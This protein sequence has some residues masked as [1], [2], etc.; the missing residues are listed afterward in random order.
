MATKGDIFQVPN[1]CKCG[2]GCEIGAKSMYRPGHDARHVSEVYKRL[3]TAWDNEPQ[4]YE[5]GT[6]Y[7]YAIN[8]LPTEALRDKLRRRVSQAG[9]KHHNAAANSM[10]DQWFASRL[11]G[12][13]RVNDATYNRDSE[14]FAVGILAAIGWDRSKVNYKYS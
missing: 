4:W 1:H 8:A 3:V 10:T 12:L 13:V 2:C 5:H 11:T 7:K 6:A 14:Y 9:W